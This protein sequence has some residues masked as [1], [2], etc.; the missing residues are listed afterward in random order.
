MKWTCWWLA[1]ALGLLGIVGAEGQTAAD[2]KPQILIVDEEHQALPKP[3]PKRSDA[4]PPK[5][6]EIEPAEAI[7]LD[8]T[9]YEL[10]FQSGDRKFNLMKPNRLDV[11]FD[12]GQ[13]YK[14]IY[15]SKRQKRLELSAK[16]LRPVGKSPPFRGFKTG[17]R[18]MMSLGYEFPRLAKEEE[19]KVAPAW[20]G[21]V[22]VLPG[23]EPEPT[24]P[25]AKTS[26]PAQDEAPMGDF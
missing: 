12:N 15:S 2:K 20:M 23:P 7:G 25:K 8:F 3:G 11:L 24:K 1:T 26:A 21:V 14:R 16:T 4:P 13:Q 19:G 17:Q 5:I 6:Y 22:E 18:F 9:N 10:R